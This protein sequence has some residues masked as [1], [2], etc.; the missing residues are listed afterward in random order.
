[1]T[2]VSE[3]FS[4]EELTATSKQIPNNPSAVEAICLTRLALLLLEKIRGLLGRPLFVVSA[5]RSETVNKAVGGS[6]KSQHL[7]GQAAD[8]STK[9]M[10]NYELFLFVYKHRNVLSFDQL[11]YEYDTNCCHISYVSE[12]ENRLNVLTRKKN[13]GVFVYSDFS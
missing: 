4:L 13:G 11:I 2:R 1:M 7:R 8:I 12:K 5:F 10:S 6:S 9:I 3:N